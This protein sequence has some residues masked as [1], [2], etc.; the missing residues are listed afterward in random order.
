MRI[1]LL[2]IT[3]KAKNF[4]R[5]GGREPFAMHPFVQQRMEAIATA[6]QVTDD[7]STED[8]FSQQE[9]SALQDI[10]ASLADYSAGLSGRTY[11]VKK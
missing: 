4:P 9:P 2:A 6:P 10:D 11:E 1:P 5:I 7:L 3:A 8:G